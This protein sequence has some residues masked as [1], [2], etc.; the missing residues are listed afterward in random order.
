MGP[1][2]GV[3]SKGHVEFATA[4][5]RS[6]LSLIHQSILGNTR[7]FCDLRPLLI[8]YLWTGAPNPGGVRNRI[9]KIKQDYKKTYDEIGIPVPASVTTLSA[10]GAG[11]KIEDG[12]VATAD[13]E[14]KKA[15]PRG[16]KRVATDID[17][18]DNEDLG[19]FGK[20]VKLE[21]SFDDGQV[22]AKVKVSDDI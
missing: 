9:A 8:I 15:A 21:N 12:K 16:R 4:L 17:S 18:E 19:A 5:G 2:G 13:K 11:G 10:K 22:E 1:R 20:K 3:G 6:I 7:R 14:K